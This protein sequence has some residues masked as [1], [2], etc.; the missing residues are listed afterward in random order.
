MIGM[1]SSATPWN[2]PSSWTRGFV[3]R[4]QGFWETWHLT[5]LAETAS[6]LQLSLWGNSIINHF[7]CEILAVLKLA[8]VDTS[9]VQLIMLMTSVLTP[10]L[11]MLLLCISIACIL[12]TPGASVDGQSKAVSTCA[13]HLIVVALFC[14]TALSPCTWKPSAIYSQETDKCMTLVNEELMPMLNLIFNSLCKRNNSCEKIT[15]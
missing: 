14:G 1:W 12:I 10:P 4:L 2:S 3:Y 15:D 9:V 13:A 8:C 6:V 5:V 11:P 7:D